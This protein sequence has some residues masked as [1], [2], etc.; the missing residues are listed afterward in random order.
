[1]F[2]TLASATLIL[3]HRVRSRQRFYEF[4]WVYSCPVC[5]MSGL[6]QQILLPNLHSKQRSYHPPNIQHLF[7]IIRKLCRVQPRY[8][9]KNTSLHIQDLN[10]QTNSIF[11]FIFFFKFK[12]EF[13]CPLV[14]QAEM[15]SIFLY[16]SALELLVQDNFLEGNL[17]IP[18]NCGGRY[19]VKHWLALQQHNE[20]E[21]NKKIQGKGSTAMSQM[22]Y[23][24]AR[25]DMAPTACNSKIRGNVL[26]C[27]LLTDVE[28][29][30]SE[31]LVKNEFNLKLY[32][33]T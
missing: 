32:I 10:Q 17:G 24:V 18:W 33:E 11:L 26:Y 2:C 8:A 7:H 15:K 20:V 9:W 23:Q 14:S 5:Y 30:F 12:K 1:M 4:Y 28:D 21:R 27:T 19:Q 16:T 22:S 13:L 6:I 25:W 29:M 3:G 31:V